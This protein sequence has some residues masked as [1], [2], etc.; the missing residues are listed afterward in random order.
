MATLCPKCSGVL[1]VPFL[2]GARAPILS[3]NLAFDCPH[4]QARLI[5]DYWSV[6]TNI[7]RVLIVLGA[8][9]L[10]FGLPQLGISV[11][12]LAGVIGAYV[13][14]S[15]LVLVRLRKVIFA[16]NRLNEEIKQQKQA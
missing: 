10:V 12:I 6:K 14:V 3:R 4:C 5:I 16:D 1:S 2:E 13:V 9:A 15:W 11:G 8:V 7:F